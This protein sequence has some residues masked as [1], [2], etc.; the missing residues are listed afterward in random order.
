MMRQR[1]RRTAGSNSVLRDYE[2]KPKH[3]QLADGASLTRFR[4]R[5]GRSRPEAVELHK[6]KRCYSSLK[7]RFSVVDDDSASM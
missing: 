1:A 3:L 6:Q 5:Q 7:T 2:V 4:T